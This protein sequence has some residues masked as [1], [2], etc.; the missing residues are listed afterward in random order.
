MGVSLT[1]IINPHTTSLDFLPCQDRDILQNPRSRQP[2]R[3]LRTVAL[4]QNMKQCIFRKPIAKAC[5]G[6]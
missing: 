1:G 5:R 3:N 6:H 4:S 2:D